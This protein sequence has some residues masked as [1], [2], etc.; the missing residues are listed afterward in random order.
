MAMIR[1]WDTC[2]KRIEKPKDYIIAEIGRFKT[3]NIANREYEKFE[4]C[5]DCAEKISNFVKDHHERKDIW[6]DTY[7]SNNHLNFMGYKTFNYG[8]LLAFVKIT[9]CIMNWRRFGIYILK[10][11]LVMKNL[12]KVIGIY[13]A[14]GTALGVGYGTGYY[15]IADRDEVADKAKKLKQKAA[16][17][18]V[19]IADKIKKVGKKNNEFEYV[20]NENEFES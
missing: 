1:H 3:A 20:G 19:K 11:T 15:L 14:V 9:R 13:L 12:V 7:D 8:F 17:K 2:N 5:N 4:I 6:P 16:G 10:E 18:V